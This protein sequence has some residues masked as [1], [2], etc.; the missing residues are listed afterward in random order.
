MT[1]SDK[2]DFSIGS[3][4][5]AILR[6][7]IPA[8][9]A[10]IINLLYSVVDR[11]YIGHIPATGSLALTGL[12]ICLPVICLVTAFTNLCGQGGAP[13][14]S[15]ARGRGDLKEA[16]RIS[17]NSFALLLIAGLVATVV[18]LAFL[19]PLL[20]FFGASEDTLP[21]A[22]AYL[23]LYLCG[24]EFVMIAS[25]MN[26][27]INA[28]GFSGYGMISVLLGAILNIALDPLFIY[29]FHMGVQGAALATVISQAVSAAWVLFFLTGN[30]AK[31]RLTRDC[32]KLDGRLC[33]RIL[34]L[35]SA[36]FFFGFTNALVELVSNR[37]LLAV[38]GDLYVGVMTILV[39][40][41][42]VFMTVPRAMTQGSQPVLSYNY[43]AGKNS[44]V[45]AGI[46]FIF[47]SMLLF[48]SVVGLFG[49]IFPRALMKIYTDDET[50]LSAGVPMMRLFFSGFWFLALQFVGQNT[51]T[52]LGKSAYA[53]TFSLLRKAVIVVPATIWLASAFGYTGVFCAEPLSDYLGAGACF[54]VMMLTVYRRLGRSETE[55]V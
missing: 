29:A 42:D 11:V 18:F 25:G 47:W 45:R 17:G 1:T 10:Q 40:L 27:H 16:A 12:G 51:F 50:L 35:G 9:V 26:F 21:Y 14:C 3:V 6:M 48:C 41:R 20:R 19:E 33:R 36:S 49:E 5:R 30:R 46:R 7:G 28:Q 31:Y 54:A 32:M 39:S 24:T 43:G 23:R 37:I 15:A 22:K 52:A 13:L 34:S 53:I 8:C 4:N 55:K 2:T 44:R 38:G